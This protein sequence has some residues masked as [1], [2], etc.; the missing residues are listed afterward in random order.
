MHC[1]HNSVDS[2]L[3]RKHSTRPG[4]SSETLIVHSESGV[5]AIGLRIVCLGKEQVYTSCELFVTLNKLL[6][7]FYKRTI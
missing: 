7:F 6:I 2:N 3:T 5:N 1:A 4:G